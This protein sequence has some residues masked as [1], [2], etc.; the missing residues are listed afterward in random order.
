MIYPS[1]RAARPSPATQ[2]LTYGSLT[3]MAVFEIVI[4]LPRSGF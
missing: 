4:S 1:K 3:F 2:L